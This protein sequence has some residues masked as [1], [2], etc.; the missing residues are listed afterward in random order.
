MRHTVKNNIF[1]QFSRPLV[2]L[3]FF[4]SGFLFVAGCTKQDLQYRATTGLLSIYMDWG[5][6]PPQDILF[7]LYPQGKEGSVTGVPFVYKCNSREFRQML[8]PGDYKI[9]LCTANASGVSY[10]GMD[11]HTTAR[12]CAVKQD[13]N[14]C[15]AQPSNVFIGNTCHHSDILHISVS[16]TLVTGITPVSLTKA[17]TFKFGIKN[18]PSLSGVSGILKGVVSAVNLFDGTQEETPCSHAFETSFKEENYIATVN[19]FD[20]ITKQEK[21][22]VENSNMLTLN[23]K[24]ISGENYN[25]TLDISKTIHDIKQANNGVI[26]ASVSILLELALVD[27]NMQAS[28][29]RWTNGS[30]SG[31]VN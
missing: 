30:G 21:T 2:F 3:T 18:F 6:T 12:V 13:E 4:L 11:N 27:G 24:G 22:P 25:V 31:S 17:V 29:S 1:R 9:L 7:Y 28:V 23:L 15:I 10:E 8:P 19:I 14:G 16:D 5:S 26:P 20:L